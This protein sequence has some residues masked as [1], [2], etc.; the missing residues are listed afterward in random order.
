MLDPLT[1]TL[2][3]A[4]ITAGIGGLVYWLKA[5]ATKKTQ[6]INDVVDLKKAVWRLTKTVL[7]L[8][9]LVDKNTRRAHPELDTELEDIARELLSSNGALV[10]EKT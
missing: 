10:D 3:G 6:H 4:I 5:R 9:K 1:L 8:A 7:I 2:I